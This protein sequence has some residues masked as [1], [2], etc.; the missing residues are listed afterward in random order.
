V[1]LGLAGEGGCAWLVKQKKSAITGKTEK[2]RL[3]YSDNHFKCTAKGA[4]S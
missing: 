3:F 2:S 4:F 1:A